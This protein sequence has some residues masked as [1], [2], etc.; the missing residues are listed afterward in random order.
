MNLIAGLCQGLIPACAGKTKGCHTLPIRE[1]AH[2]R[3]CGE[4]EAVLAC[5]LYGVG[6][7]PRVRGKLL[8]HV[9][10]AAEHRLIPACAGKTTLSPTSI[11]RQTAHPRVCGEN[12]GPLVASAPKWG[13]SPRVRGKTDSNINNH[14]QRRAHPRVCGEN[15][16]RRTDSSWNSGSSPRVRGKLETMSWLAAASRL[17]P[18]CAGKT[19]MR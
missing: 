2:P 13:S 1:W 19:L 11:P 15:A 16:P 8:L 14:R 6:S 5:R 18:A 12:R 9:L 4:N 17:I 7:S 3:V 10:V